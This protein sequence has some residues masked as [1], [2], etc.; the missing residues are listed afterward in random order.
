MFVEFL[1]AKAQ[2]LHAPWLVAPAN[3][4]D[5][6]IPPEPYVIVSPGSND[7][8]RNWPATRYVEVVRRLRDTF[9]ISVVVCGGPSEKALGNQFVQEFGDAVINLAGKTSLLQL[10]ALIRGAT[11]VLTNDTGPA[12]LAVALA[13]PSVA[14]VGGGHF[15]RFLPYPEELVGQAQARHASTYMP[16]YECRWVCKFEVAQGAPFPCVD[17]VTVEQVWQKV[18]ALL[19]ET[20]GIR[21]IDQMAKTSA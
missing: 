13:V 15:G 9:C 12:H 10:I 2:L 20:H 19:E 11:L 8:R 18:E 14:I 4:A 6:Q 7:L 16:C 1:G 17:H 3:E 21:S 5:L